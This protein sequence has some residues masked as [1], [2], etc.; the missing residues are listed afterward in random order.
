MLWRRAKSCPGTVTALLQLLGSV[1]WHQVVR[2]INGWWIGNNVEGSGHDL[3]QDTSPVFRLEGWWRISVRSDCFLAKLWTLMDEELETM[4]KEVVT[5]YFKI[6]PQC[7]A[8]R[9]DE[10]PR[11][12]A[13]VF[14]QYL[15]QSSQKCCCDRK[16]AE[17]LRTCH[18]KTNENLNTLYKMFVNSENRGV[19]FNAVL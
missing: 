3:F 14:G 9:D 1:T 17:L 19:H 16:L 18:H 15:N 12:E 7:F 13:T 2:R 11:S 4:W 10:E 5:T 6:L 8:W